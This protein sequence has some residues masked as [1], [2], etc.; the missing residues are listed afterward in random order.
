MTDDLLKYPKEWVAAQ[1]RVTAFGV[2]GAWDPPPQAWQE[3]EL[4]E[5]GSFT[6]SKGETIEQG[7]AL[8][9]WL[10][11]QTGRS[12]LDFYH[13]PDPGSEDA[14]FGD[15]GEAREAAD[16]VINF[17]APWMRRSCPD[18]GRLALG[19]TARSPVPDVRTGYQI[20]GSMLP[21]RIDPDGSSDFSYQINRPRDLISVPGMRVNRLSQWGVIQIG[22]LMADLTIRDGGASGEFQSG[23]SQHWCQAVLDINTAPSE[24][25]IPRDKVPDVLAE[26][27]GLALE[28]VEKGDIK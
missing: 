21:V 15:I 8:G 18:I 27:L 23:R 25:A 16:R 1:V 19:L 26:F 9:H 11:V 17:V 20:L 10:V 13:V 14:H 7:A 6:R 24:Q 3:L 28:I 5:A 22:Q 4:G 2:G 12:R